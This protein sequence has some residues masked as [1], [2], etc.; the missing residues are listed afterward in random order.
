VQPLPQQARHNLGRKGAKVDGGALLELCLLS[1]D[2]LA[3]LRPLPHDVG[4]D[5]NMRLFQEIDGGL[6]QRRRSAVAHL[7]AEGYAEAALLHALVGAIARSR[8]VA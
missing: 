5:N 1:E 6:Q 3:E 2:L 4:C 8:G 7:R